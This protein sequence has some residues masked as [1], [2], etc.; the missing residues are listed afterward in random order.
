MCMTTAAA[1]RLPSLIGGRGT[2]DVVRARV[3]RQRLQSDGEGRD[4]GDWAERLAGR[5][6][7]RAS[8][9]ER[10]SRVPDDTVH[11]LSAP[12]A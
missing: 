1:L 12:S 3:R 2:A 4:R 9:R 8:V 11:A 6:S 7:E 10:P 5:D